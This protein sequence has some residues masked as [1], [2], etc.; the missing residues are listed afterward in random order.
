M[1]DDDNDDDDDDD[2]EEECQTSSTED[3]TTIM[4]GVRSEKWEIANKTSVSSK[5]RQAT[6]KV[7]LASSYQIF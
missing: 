5:R 1:D 3:T 4:E 6:H 7:N 2:D